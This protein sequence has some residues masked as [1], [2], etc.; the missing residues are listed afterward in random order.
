MCIKMKCFK[1]SVWLPSTCLSEGNYL[2]GSGTQ[3]FIVFLL[4]QLITPWNIH[5]MYG[6]SWTS[7][8]ESANKKESTC[9]S[10]IV[11]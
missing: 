8:K 4:S 2:W 9:D 11:K 3:D 5:C 6:C 7:C 10:I 1:V